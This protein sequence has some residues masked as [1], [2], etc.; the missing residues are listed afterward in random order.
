MKNIVLTGFMASGKSTIARELARITGFRLLDTDKMIEAA[1]N[2]SC[3]EIFGAHGEEYFRECEKKACIAAGNE[4]NVII[5]T[6]GGVVLNRENIDALRKNGVIFNL[7]PGCA[8]ILKRL[9]A[10][11]TA[12]PLADGESAENIIARYRARQSF[13]DNCDRKI[14]VSEQLSPYEYAMRIIGMMR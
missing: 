6:G 10:R 3:E 5:A 2:M 7:E 13:Y 8:L 4:K 12:R 1:E 11:K 14:D 9:T